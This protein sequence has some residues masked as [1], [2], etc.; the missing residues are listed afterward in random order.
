M[1][2][3]CLAGGLFLKRDLLRRAL[4]G[5]IFLTERG[6]RVLNARWIA[7]AILLAI[8]NE[9]VWRHFSTDTWVAFKASVTVVSIIGYIAITRLTAPHYWEPPVAAAPH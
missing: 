6:W 5:Q 4:E 9:I 1:F 2:A 3:L 7:F 8:A